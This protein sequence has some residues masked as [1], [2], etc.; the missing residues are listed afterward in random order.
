MLS[1]TVF[2]SRCPFFVLEEANYITKAFFFNCNNEFLSKLE[3]TAEEYIS[4]L[5]YS[6]LDNYAAIISNEEY[7][8]IQKDV[9]KSNQDKMMFKTDC[10]NDRNHNTR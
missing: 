7:H 4:W 9:G 3:A 6:L 1:S 10:T 8:L 5:Y 2:G